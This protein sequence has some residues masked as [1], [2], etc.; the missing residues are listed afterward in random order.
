MC[1]AVIT[2]KVH[3]LKQLKAERD[4]LDRKIEK[5]E[6][7][8]KEKM[9]EQNVYE[10]EG[11]DYKVTWNEVESSRFNQKL[12]ESEYPELYLKFKVLSKTRRFLIG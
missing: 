7:Y 10:F 4:A 1:Q 6:S 8:I 3:E 2:K 12:F 11:D 5:I 9:V